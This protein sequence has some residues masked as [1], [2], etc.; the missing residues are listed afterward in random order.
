MK[1]YGKYF[2]TKIFWY[3]ITLVVALVL[4]F[5]LPR[6]MPG[7][8]V[9]MIAAGVTEGMTDTSAIQRVMDEY[10]ARFGLDKPMWEQFIIF[11][12]NLLRGDLGVSFSNYPRPVTDILR[13]ALPWTIGL[14]LPSILIGWFLGNLLGAVA[15]Y[16]RGWVDKFLMPFFLFL[17]C[18]P[19]FG[20][21]IILLYIFGVNLNWFPTSGGYSFDMLP[22][23][24]WAFVRSLLTHYIMPSTA[25]IL[26]TI[27]GQSIGMRSM[28]IY[29][30]NADYVKYSRFMGIKDGRTIR[31][32]FRNAMLPQVTGLAT[33]IGTMVGGALVS[34]IIFSYPGLGTMLLS[35]ISGRDYPLISGITLLITIGVLIA[36]LAL[37]IIYGLIDPRIKASQQEE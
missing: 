25:I 34:E 36:N 21:A 24:T 5:L 6:L 4:N 8:P 7:N 14:Q 29:E 9:S 11:V 3:L 20:M 16:Q 2:I 17:G 37:E 12:R 27:G 22:A 33:S 10:A 35:A 26:T 28:A 23:P 13:Q 18:M 19:A 32:V 15:A 30:L 31:Y 1:A